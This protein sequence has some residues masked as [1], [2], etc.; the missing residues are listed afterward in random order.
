MPQLLFLLLLFTHNAFAQSPILQIDTG[1]HKALIRDIAFTPDGKYLVSASNDKTIRVW[2][3]QAGKTDRIIRGQI[4]EGDEGKIFAM[5]LSPDERWLAVGG[6]FHNSNPIIGSTIRLYHFPTGQLTGLLKGHN[7]VVLSLAFSPNS[8]Y[9]VSGSGDYTA[10]IWEVKTQQPLHTLHGHTKEIYAVAFTSDN[11]RVV[12][13]SLDHDLRLWQVNTGKQ[14]AVLL[15]HRDKVRAV[16]ISPTDGT[17]ASGSK[18]YTIRL[19]NGNTGQLIKQLANQGTMIGSLSFSPN[20]QLLLSSCGGATNG[21]ANNSEN[22]WSIPSG[23]QL[24]KYREHDNIVLATAISPDGRWAATGGGSN[25]EI[26]IWDINTGKTQQRLQGVGASTWA[27]GLTNQWLAWGNTD[28]GSHNAQQEPFE[29]QLHLTTPTQPHPIDNT[30]TFNRAQ[31]E[32]QQWSLERQ[33]GSSDGRYPI[34]DIKKNQKTVAQVERGSTD[35]Y[36]HS[37]YTFTPNGQQ[38][39]SGGGN[40]NLAAYDKQGNKLGD[41]VGHT[42]DIWAVAVSPDGQLLASGSDDQTVRLWNV[43]TFE[44][45]LTLFRGTNNEWVIWTPQGYY[46]SSIN[47]DN[48]VGWQIN[49]GADKNPDYITANQVRKHFL[50]PDIITDAIRLRSAKQAVAQARNIRFSL[51]DLT[52]KQPPNFDIIHPQ[53]NSHTRQQYTTLEIQL[54]TNT[55]GLDTIEVYVNG[56]LA[57]N[58]RFG[59]IAIPPTGERKTFNIGLQRGENHIEVVAKNAVG[60]TRK[61]LIVHLEHSGALDK[62]GDLY[63][64]AVGVSRYQEA[65][66]SLKYADND[67]RELHAQLTRLAKNSYKKVHA[68]LL[69]DGATPPTADNIRDALDILLSTQPEDTTVIFLSGHGV[70]E[71]DGYYFLPYDAQSRQN[72]WRSSTTVRWTDIQHAI[73]NSQGKRLLLVDTCHSGGAINPALLKNVADENIIVIAST[74][75]NNVA[76]EIPDLK[77]GVM[78]YALI[79]GLKGKA[80]LVKDNKI[81]F[82]ELDTYVSSEV[83]R[84]TNNAQIPVSHAPNGFKDFELARLD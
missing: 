65:S 6:M 34:L 70:Q 3:W 28:V 52:K 12:T 60:E 21:C 24:M 30:L 33:K 53:N 42:G 4:N 54:A 71:D 1:G 68:T 39:I 69:T 8:R 43:N 80:D 58:P 36:G 64:I 26:H 63:L 55:Q 31:T 19:W 57:G 84:L 40:G 7:N 17:I 41:Y 9:L 38:I 25:Q 47:G 13:G 11:Q 59:K 20:G 75:Y 27:V 77:H 45:I 32:W 74:D 5:A 76:Q 23:K 81:Y 10:M 29:H 44:N 82:K 22:L 46:A 35:G 72:R 2:D 83:K 15:G 51:A 48:M 79:E 61:T 49:K 62:Q 67:A 16:A 73:Q 37:A 14:L 66:L 56:T 18:D 50:R 78:A